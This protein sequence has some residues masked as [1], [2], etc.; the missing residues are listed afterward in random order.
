MP[1]SEQGAI[2]RSLRQNHKEEQTHGPQ[3]VNRVACDRVACARPMIFK[4]GEWQA[5]WEVQHGR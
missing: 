1:I 3:L 5:E 2:E 4:P